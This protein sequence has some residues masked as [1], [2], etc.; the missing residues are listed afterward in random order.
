LLYAYLG[1]L[2]PVA[3]NGNMKGIPY[4]LYLT[5]SNR[6]CN[7]SGNFKKERLT[8]KPLPP[9]TYATTLLSLA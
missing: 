3:E 6:D 5:C 9:P 8:W 7:C 4:V 2:K 1:V